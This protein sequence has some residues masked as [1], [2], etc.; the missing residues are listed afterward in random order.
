MLVASSKIALLTWSGNAGQM[1]SI[2]RENVW[3][4]WLYP[5]QSQIINLR[6]PFAKLS[7]RLKLKSM[8]GILNL[9]IVLAVKAV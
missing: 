5:L 9:A 6:K 8:I 3:R 1:P 4:L 2:L 7:T